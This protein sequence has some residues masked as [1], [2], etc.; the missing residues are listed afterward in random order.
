MG[1]ITSPLD[2]IPAGEAEAIASLDQLTL[3]GGRYLSGPADARY[4][5]TREHWLYRFHYRSGALDHVTQAIRECQVP[6]RTI[7]EMLALLEAMRES[8]DPLAG[9]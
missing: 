5:I 1:K 6:G 8:L 7:A 4:A 9:S 3:A 2:H